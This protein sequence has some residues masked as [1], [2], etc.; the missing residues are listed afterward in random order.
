MVFARPRFIPRRCEQPRV[1]PL[2]ARLPRLLEDRGV[3]AVLRDRVGQGQL[4]CTVSK[5]V[6]DRGEAGRAMGDRVLSRDADTPCSWPASC[7]TWRPHV[8]M[9]GFARA[10]ASSLRVVSSESSST[11]VAHMTIERA[12]STET[13]MSTARNVSAWNDINGTPNCLRTL[14]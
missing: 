1:A 10:A 13:Y 14:R 6:V 3:G 2:K 4:V 7:P 8:L 11:S 9:A 5:Q 12:S